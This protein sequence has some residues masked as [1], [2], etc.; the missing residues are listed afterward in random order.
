MSVLNFVTLDLFKG[1]HMTAVSPLATI[2]PWARW[3][4]T[5]N[6]QKTTR[7]STTTRQ[8]MATCLRMDTELTA[9]R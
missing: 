2:S 4:T 8:P 7:S 5:S 6:T 3:C 1:R 9:A